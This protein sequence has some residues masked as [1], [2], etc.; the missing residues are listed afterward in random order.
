LLAA[1]ASAD[2]DAEKPKPKPK[3]KSSAC[4]DDEDVVLKSIQYTA[5]AMDGSSVASRQVDN[6]LLVMIQTL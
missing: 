6:L 5:R 2:A 4:T 3:P 1:T